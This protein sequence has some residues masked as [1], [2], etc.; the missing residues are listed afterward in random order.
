[1]IAYQ[2][3]KQQRDYQELG[4]DYFARLNA[5]GLKRHLLRRLAKLGYKATLEPADSPA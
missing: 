4:E 1:M 5:E 2:L 3:R